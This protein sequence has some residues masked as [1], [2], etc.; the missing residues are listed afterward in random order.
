MA[1]EHIHVFL[2]QQMRHA[3]GRGTVVQK[4]SYLCGLLNPV[5]V[6]T[7]AVKDNSLVVFDG[8][9]NH[10]MKGVFKIL[11]PFQT[12]GINLKALG[13]RT[14]EH[15]VGA[16][17]AVGGTKHTELK[18]IAGKG[19]R[20]RPVAVCGISVKLWQNIHAQ[21]HLCLFRAFIGRS[22]FNCLQNG[23]QLIS[24]EHGNN[25]GGRFVCPKPVV[26]SRRGDGKAEQILIIV[27]RLNHCAEEKQKL[28]VF[29]RG[30][31]GR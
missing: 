10:L 26:V 12:V 22:A 16:G 14:V 1:G 27:N 13:N 23:V 11:R 17:N 18:L 31:P 2:I 19:K 7:V 6:I 15:H 29:I 8:L 21:L 28:R 24:Q 3:V 4:T 25:G 20:R 30:F 9:A 5:I